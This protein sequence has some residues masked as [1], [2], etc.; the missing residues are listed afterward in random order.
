MLKQTIQID[1][2][3]VPKWQPYDLIEFMKQWE[4]RYKEVLVERWLWVHSQSFSF[5]LI[6]IYWG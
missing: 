4:V 1:L 2:L 5:Y 6:Y 3:R